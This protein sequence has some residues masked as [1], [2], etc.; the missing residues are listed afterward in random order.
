MRQ[1]EQ[2]VDCKADNILEDIKNS[3]K[4]LI[5]RGFASHWP[6]VKAGLE[7]AQQAAQYLLKF[8]NGRPVSGCLAPPEAK[9]RIYYNDALTGFN[10]N[11][12]HVPLAVVME[13]L[14]QHV[15]DTQAPGMYVASTDAE[16]WFPDLI[17]ENF[18]DLQHENAI[19][20]VWIGNKT[21]IAAHY[22]FPQNIAVSAVGRRRFTLF[23]PEQ[24]SNLYVGPLEFAPGGQAISMV[25]MAQP[26]F[27]KH[28]RFKEALDAAF[29]A[30][31]EPGDALL[32]PS[33]WWHHVEALDD[34]NVLVT[35]WWRN[36]PAYMG[37]PDHALSAALLA[38]RGLPEAQKQ[39]WKAIFDHY[40]FSDSAASVDHIP[41]H[42][43]AQL[44]VP[45]SEEKALQLRADLLN[46]LK[47]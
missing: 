28:P 41:E 31:L 34:F 47:Q 7:G 38:L 6:L 14:L 13:K 17:R 23:P 40:I 21:R 44:S 33:M 36:S 16:Q 12:S 3:A 32:L 20:N 43:R 5:L 46:K 25:D 15:G 29:I 19:A 35:H 2:V 24:I 1:V 39:A 42:V 4:P 26:D 45:L 30:E 11:A 22:D 10:F 37:K 27:A 9:G 18:A 8:Y